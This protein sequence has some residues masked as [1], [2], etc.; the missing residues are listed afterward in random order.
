MTKIA[1]WTLVAMSGLVALVIGGDRLL[2]RF[3][4]EWT[5]LTRGQE[6]LASDV[7]LLEAFQEALF[8]VDDDDRDLPS[9]PRL[10]KWTG[11]IRVYLHGRTLGRDRHFVSGLLNELSRLTGLSMRLASGDDAGGGYVDVYSTERENVRARLQEN[12]FFT[13]LTTAEAETYFLS[14]EKA[15]CSAVTSYRK[16]ISDQGIVLLRRDLTRGVRLSCLVEEIYQVLGLAADTH[17]VP[18]SIISQSRP[19]MRHITVNDKILLRTLYDARLEPGM[20]PEQVEP[21]AR[22]IIGELAAAV[23]A[24]GEEALY[25]R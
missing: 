9:T 19:Y 6:T 10:V 14:R 17:A 2:N 22:K 18:D 25:Q 23:K 3:E 15:E 12:G 8:G 1:L 4:W 13:P 11:G 5:Q 16:W 21:V 7:L 24:R 20:T